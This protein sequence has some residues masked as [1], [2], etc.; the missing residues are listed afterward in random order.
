MIC[1]KHKHKNACLYWHLN[2][3]TKEIWCWCTGKCQRSY[4]IYE[5]CYLTGIKINEIVK[6]D[7][8]ITENENKEIEKIE[9]PN[10]FK[11]LSDPNSKKALE[12]LEKRNLK[13]IEGLFYDSSREGIVFPYYYDDQFAGAQ[14]RFLNPKISEDG[15]TQKI[16]TIPGTRVS[17]LFFN[18]NQKPFSKNIKHIVITEGAFNAISL[19]QAL[20]H[21][22]GGRL[23]NPFKCIALSGSNVSDYHAEKLR[24]LIK[25]DYNI[26][27]APDND[28]AGLKML[29]KMIDKF[30]CTHYSLIEEVGKDWN[31]LLIEKDYK[32]A[33]YFLKN[34]RSLNEKKG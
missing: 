31:D 4:S 34:M 21:Y 32:L 5:Y 24:K 8:P 18:W 17:N 13:L 26:I 11:F 27:S 29:K 1:K 14:I 22:Y 3:D 7:I 2:P 19:Q 20:N 12:Y 16:S 9:W 25:L 23:D 33:K 10:N 30:A 15:H 28:E 6:G